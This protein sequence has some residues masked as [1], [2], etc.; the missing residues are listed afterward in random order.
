MAAH[1]R[2]L[3]VL[4]VDD[5]EVNREI[6]QQ[7]LANWK[8]NVQ[9]ASD[10]PSAL[11]MLKQGVQDGKPIDVVILDWHMPDMDGIDLAKAIR[12]TAE[13]HA[14]QLIML[15]SVEDRLKTEELKA[16]GLASYLV[17]PI[18]QS[19]LFNAIAEAVVHAPHATTPSEVAA[20]PAAA[21]PP[22]QAVP[23][24]VHLLLVEDNEINQMVAQEIL[25]K[26]GYSCDVANNGREAV[27]A[28]SARRYPVVLMDCQMPEMDGF[29]ATRAI[30]QQEKDLSR[31]GTPGH[32]PIIA[33]TA[34]AVKGDRETCLAAGMDYYVSKPIQPAE[35]LAAIAGALA[36]YPMSVPAEGPAP[37]AGAVAP[38]EPTAAQAP[39]SREPSTASA[40]LSPPLDV[41]SLVARCMGDG[42]FAG[43]ILDTFQKQVTHDLES[44]AKSLSERDIEV[45][46][47]V[48]HTIKGTAANLSADRVRQAA[49]ELEQ[50]GRRHDLDHA[51]E[52]MDRLRAEL[53]CCLAY[54]PEAK[55]AAAAA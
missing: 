23:R 44:L 42:G 46:T 5:N 55:A 41:K 3:R 9:L 50:L 48:A 4:G 33:L 51:Q 53:E 15:T 31:G 34:N 47:R 29:E 18:R 6:L 12:A 40:P 39:P 52:A 27:K 20:A 30:R 13:L 26:A 49:F 32:L 37:V 10:G 36:Q 28:V 25:R 16:L 8:L 54:L 11:R 22:A 43:K 7:Q 14:T 19:R 21:C 45:F 35:L 38:A 17:K 1:I 2:N 24:G